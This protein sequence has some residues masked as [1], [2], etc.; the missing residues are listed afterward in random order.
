MKTVTFNI[1]PDFDEMEAVEALW[2][3]GLFVRVE[4]VRT[5]ITVAGMPAQIDRARLIMEAYA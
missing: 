1:R 2:R 5:Q 3:A 4:Q